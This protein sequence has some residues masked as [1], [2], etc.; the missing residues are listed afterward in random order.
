VDLL[1]RFLSRIQSL[2]RWAKLMLPQHGGEDGVE[3]GALTIDQAERS[4]KGT[5]T[6]FFPSIHP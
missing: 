3:S 5:I 4:N 2:L 1:F 6:Y